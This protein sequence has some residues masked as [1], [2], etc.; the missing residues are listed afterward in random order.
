MK[1]VIVGQEIKIDHP[2][3][4]GHWWSF[5]TLYLNS[6]L[7][8]PFFLAR[9]GQAP[10]VV[11]PNRVP[12]DG[13]PSLLFY[14]PR[15]V[16]TDA[17][18]IQQVI[19]NGGAVVLNRPERQV[20]DSVQ[21]LQWAAQAL[22]TAP[23]ESLRERWD[24]GS[25]RTWY[26]TDQELYDCYDAAQGQVLSWIGEHPNLIVREKTAI[27][28]ANPWPTVVRYH[29]TPMFARLLLD[30]AEL[31]IRA[32]AQL[33]GLELR[34]AER[35]LMARHTEL[36][37][38]FHA[39]G[40][41]AFTVEQLEK[42]M[43]VARIDLHEARATT[44]QAARK[45]VA[46]DSSEA[47]ALLRLAFHQLEEENRKLQPEPAIFTDTLHGGGLFGDIGYCEFDWPQHA[48]DVLHNHLDW[49]ELRG[50]RFN[51][52]FA[53]KSLDHMSK[54]FP[55]LFDRLRVAQ[56][57]GSVEIVNGTWNQ[58]YPPFFTLESIIRQ[59]D[60][61]ADKMQELFHRAP[62]TYAS[63][64]FGFAPQL[65]AVLA[66]HGFR[67]AVLRV[68]NM[69]DAPTVADP[70][71]KWT[72]PNGDEILTLPSH[73]YKSE[74]RNE[75]TYNNLHLKLF[76][77]A[78]ANIPSPF[79]FTG[80]GDLTYY[81]PFREELARTAYYAN[82][83]GQFSTWSSYFDGKSST[84]APAL[85]TTM[86]DFD[87]RAAFVELSLWP[88]L[89]STAGGYIDHCMR[90][91]AASELFRAAELLDALGKEQDAHC[92]YGEW[93]QS[94]AAFQGHDRY[95]AVNFPSGGFMGGANDP[96]SLLG[97][98]VQT[99]SDYCGPWDAT[100]LGKRADRDLATAEKEATEQI[101]RK[102]S[103]LGGDGSREP[104]WVV[105][106]PGPASSRIVKFPK[107][108]GRKLLLENVELP[109]QD[110]GDDRLAAV[111]A[112]AYACA[113][114]HAAE[115][116]AGSAIISHPVK[117]GEGYLDNGLL[118][119][120]F[121]P[122]SGIIRRLLARNGHDWQVLLAGGNRFG[123]P[124]SG[125]QRCLELHWRHTGPL[126]ASAELLLAM[127]MPGGELCKI[128]SW[129]SL[130]AGQTYLDLR[131]TI[132]S[133]PPIRGE[134]WENHLALQFD[135]PGDNFRLQRSHYNVLEEA[136]G[137]RIFSLNLLLA[138]GDPTRVA[139]LN[140]GNQFY[141]RDG[142]TI[143]AI[144]LCENE[145][146]R[147]FSH[148]VGYAL[149]N[150]L[151]EARAWLSPWFTSSIPEGSSLRGARPRRAIE[152]SS[153]NVELLSLTKREGRLRIRLANMAAVETHTDVSFPDGVSD[154]WTCRLNG[155]RIDRLEVGDN[156]T[157][158][159]LRPW[160][161][162]QIEAQ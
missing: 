144:L 52:D 85:R 71:V 15:T 124:G 152:I 149:G 72:A 28:A 39:F 127:D 133:C 17:D 135:L 46:G 56:D 141:V 75:V 131:Q 107:M 11:F 65:A 123:A 86:E 146:A 31:L 112:P 143:A 10:I 156:R 153:E 161:I 155:E 154:A 33:T 110:D 34:P 142:R 40:F 37:R 159:A 30:L 93:W 58:P 104:S 26:Y 24:L 55:R 151:Y 1:P 51:I 54:R 62:L 132:E 137:T 67:N 9:T 121:D 87:C 41:A 81:R 122:A 125:T 109:A 48:A 119:V 68:Q 73:A 78:A 6:L 99:V 80:L 12:D 103:Q 79:V 108:A 83:F 130:E 29:N 50:Y 158:V 63:Q 96:S 16:A 94:L 116:G 66:Q 100:T 13:H 25:G 97:R 118:S 106:N 114:I 23:I 136:R 2:M 157:K 4:Q 60:L 8:D 43:G 120:E 91:A 134:Q 5:E 115:S 38:D 22:A 14:A 139:L 84:S 64:E 70:F 113:L 92:A 59:F 111:K 3:G 102:L 7:H 147:E 35:E 138:D 98:T 129:L 61:G 105:F 49:A 47:Q 145:S 160:D 19:G 53:A 76:A 74:Q 90:S 20:L 69:G 126:L 95:F 36:R 150:P 89:R 101:E 32:T 77:A 117:C 57:R 27:F 42:C 21:S 162:V 140:R 82:V 18:A 45:L 148:R 88:T 128:R 44:V